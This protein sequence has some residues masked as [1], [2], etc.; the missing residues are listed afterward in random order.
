[1]SGISDWIDF[2]QKN[3]PQSNAVSGGIL[4]MFVSGIQVGWIFNNELISFPWARGHTTLQ[5]TL[6]YVSFYVAAVAGLYL[7]GLTVNRLMKSNVYVS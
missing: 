6:T 3:K 5:I 4:V 2:N 1:M 7:A